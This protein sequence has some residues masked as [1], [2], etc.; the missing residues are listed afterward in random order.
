MKK[1]IVYVTQKDIEKGRPNR[2]RSCPIYRAVSRR[3]VDRDVYVS[4]YTIRIGGHIVV[5][6]IKA[7]NFIN[8]FD[9]RRTSSVVK[10]FK[11]AIEVPDDL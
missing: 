3:V 7:S 11:F 9:Y 5:L 8:L 1:V 6:P 4:S 2:P 10:P